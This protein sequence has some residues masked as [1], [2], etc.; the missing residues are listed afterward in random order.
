[1]DFGALSL[2]VLV[3]QE[4]DDLPLDLVSEAGQ[5]QILLDGRWLVFD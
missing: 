5:Y 2:V 1:M 4:V 3:E